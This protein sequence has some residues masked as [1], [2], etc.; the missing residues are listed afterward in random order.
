MKDVIVISP[1][2]ADGWKDPFHDRPVHNGLT[3]FG[4]V[5]LLLSYRCAF[6]AYLQRII[7]N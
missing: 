7:S 2:R 4:K 3:E 6:S 5:S 1:Y